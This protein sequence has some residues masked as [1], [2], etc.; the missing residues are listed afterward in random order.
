[1]TNT[2]THPDHPAGLDRIRQDLKAKKRLAALSGPR[3]QD[4]DPPPGPVEF[5]DTGPTRVAVLLDR[6]LPEWLRRARLNPGRSGALAL[7]AVAA[8]VALVAVLLWPSGVA[9]E[10]APPMP[11]VPVAPHQKTSQL[12]V[13]VV[14]RV[15]KP[16]L[17]S[18]PEGARVADAVRAAGGALPDA[19]PA[20]VNL[21]RKISDGEQVVVGAP[22]PATG[23]GEPSA[24]GNS[25]ISLN[26][27]TAQQF[28]GLP[29]VGP[30][31]AQR[32]VQWRTKNGRFSSVDQL[33]EVDGIGSSRLAKLR[34]L[35]TL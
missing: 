15:G 14:G 10:P 11:A 20:T 32:I 3:S 1:M 22:A 19:D 2:R 7:A 4:P 25:K 16:G 13:S 8:F 33:R 29:G 27:A 35:V 18:L 28:D 12:V 9:A 24:G 6:L 21:A 31:T 5:T 23:D 26:T 17:V 34:D 30:V